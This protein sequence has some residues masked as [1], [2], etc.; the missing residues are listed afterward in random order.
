MDVAKSC[1][2]EI[3]GRVQNWVDKRREEC[4]NMTKT[5]PTLLRSKCPTAL[6]SFSKQ[7]VRVLQ[8]NARSPANP[9]SEDDIIGKIGDTSES[10]FC[11]CRV[12]RRMLGA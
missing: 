12:S 11:L 2:D 7:E 8:D 9:S 5:N 6:I 1:I 3:I 10:T 4:E